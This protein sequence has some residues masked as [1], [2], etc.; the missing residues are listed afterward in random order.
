M[1]DKRIVILSTALSDIESGR[2]TSLDSE[3]FTTTAQ[4]K[5]AM[6]QF[7]TRN[8]PSVTWLSSYID[9]T[10]GIRKSVDKELTTESDTVYKDGDYAYRAS[11]NEVAVDDDEL[12]DWEQNYT[13]SVTLT[14]V[15]TLEIDIDAESEED[16]CDKIRDNIRDGDYEYQM[17]C[18]DDEDIE[19]DNIEITE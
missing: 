11:I 16:A 6:L 19:I 13:A 14:R 2:I 9:N 3:V 17:D 15:Y 8:D 18:P 1:S 7:A 10:S 12:R 5:L 4:A